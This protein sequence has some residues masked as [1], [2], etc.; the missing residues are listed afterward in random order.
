MRWSITT[1]YDGGICKLVVK[2]CDISGGWDEPFLVSL[3]NANGSSMNYEVPKFV[4][5]ILALPI[6]PF[7]G[8]SVATP[9]SEWKIPKLIL[10]NMEIWRRNS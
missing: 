5:Q 7:I 6:N 9:R 8:P 2:R 1:E 3:R 4:K 10:S